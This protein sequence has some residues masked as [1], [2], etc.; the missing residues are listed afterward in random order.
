MEPKFADVP[1]EL[2]ARVERLLP[3]GPGGGRSRKPDR[4]ILAGVVYRLRTGCQWKALPEQFG[5]G[6]TCHRRFQEWVRE[7]VFTKLF[8]EM[9][10]F[11]E[12]QRGIQWDWAA[13]DGFMSKSPKGGT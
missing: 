4:T 5:S 1:D 2:W 9:L 10:R 11:Y 13:I 12:E 7:D 3:K 6:S 8:T